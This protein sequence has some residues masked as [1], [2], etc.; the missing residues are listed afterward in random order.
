MKD[1]RTTQTHRKRPAPNRL[2][3]DFWSSFQRLYGPSSRPKPHDLS[4]KSE[5]QR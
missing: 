2:S 3:P 5:L 1:Y 4:S